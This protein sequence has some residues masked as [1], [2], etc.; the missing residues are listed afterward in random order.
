MIKRFVTIAGLVLSAVCAY[1]LPMNVVCRDTAKQV[2]N[3]DD[4]LFV[5]KGNIEL[6][7][8]I[9]KADWYSIEQ[10]KVVITNDSLALTLDDGGY[11]LVKEGV[12]YNPFYVFTCKPAN[13]GMTIEPTCENTMLHLTGDTK[14]YTYLRPDGTRGTLERMC[15]ISYTALSWQGEQWSDSAAVAEENLAGTIFLPALYGETPVTLCYDA[16]IRSRLDL[17]SACVSDTLFIDSVRAVNHHLTSLATARGVE[18]EDSNERNRPTSQELIASSEYSGALEV[19]FYSNPTPAAQYYHW[20][21]YKSTEKLVSRNDQ[22]IRYTF[23]EPGTYRVVCYV[24]NAQCTS[25]ST[26]VTVAIAESYLA[27]PNVFTPNGDGV[28]DEFRVSY[29]SLREFH[30][31]VYN[32]WGK[33]VYEWTDPAKGWDGTIGGRPAAEGAYFYV[34]RALGTDAAKDAGYIGLKAN[35]TK[36]KLNADESVIGVYQLSGDINLLRGKSK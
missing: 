20:T 13:I 30:C 5:F 18:G 16:E 14:S 11:Y 32:R 12:S 17:D 35:Y 24:N 10:Q 28:N 8:T 29:R 33:L 21:I 7:S 4:T 36:K 22:D 1:A 23:S 19:A 34:I 15:T 26:E 31:W 9:G 6:R 3:G 2:V 27:V 25:D